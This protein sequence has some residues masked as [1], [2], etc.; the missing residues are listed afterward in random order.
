MFGGVGDCGVAGGVD[1]GEVDIR[2]LAVGVRF[3][4]CASAALTGLQNSKP[5]SDDFG[6][7]HIHY[8]C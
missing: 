7:G 8:N 1:T 4:D 3:F 2:V 6:Y 5:A